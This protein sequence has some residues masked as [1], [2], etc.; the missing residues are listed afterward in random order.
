MTRGQRLL[1]WLEALLSAVGRRSDAVGRAALPREG[2]VALSASGMARC[3]RCC[4]AANLASIVIRLQAGC[5]ITWARPPRT[6]MRAGSRWPASAPRGAT[7]E[8]WC[9]MRLTYAGS[10]T[11]RHAAADPV[12]R[13]RST[14]ASADR[15]AEPSDDPHG[16]ARLRMKQARRTG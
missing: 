11:A 14:A 9:S 15:V 5:G 4:R 10:K 1:A 12:L 7:A 13:Y 3:S 2:A 16:D 6:A 8:A